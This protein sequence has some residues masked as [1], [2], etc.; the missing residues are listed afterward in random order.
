MS[1]YRTPV[2]RWRSDVA[3]SIL[4]WEFVTTKLCGM[5]IASLRAELGMSL[6]AFANLLGLKSKGQMS[7]IEA[8]KSSV[9][10]AVALRLEDLSAGRIDAA[11]LN[12]VVAQAR[13]VKAA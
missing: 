4:T 3:N 12:T 2:K 9:S 10:A 8:G 1:N 11:S 6:E 7:L 13:R 5:E